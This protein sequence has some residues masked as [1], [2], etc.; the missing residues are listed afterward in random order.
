VRRFR[1][2]WLIASEQFDYNVSG[3]VPWRL[4][5]TPTVTPNTTVAPDGTTSGDTIAGITTGSNVYQY[6]WYGGIPTPLPLGVLFCPS[7][8]LALPNLALNG[9]FGDGSSWTLGAGWAITGGA[10]CATNASATI[11]E[12]V[13]IIQNKVYRVTYTVSG[14]AGGWVRSVCGGTN[15]GANRTANGTYVDS[16]TCSNASDPYLYFQCSGFTGNISN[17]SVYDISG[18][19]KLANPNGG[20]TYGSWTIDFSK[21]LVGWNRIVPGH[22]AVTPTTPFTAQGNKSDGFG[23]FYFSGT[24]PLSFVA[25]GAQINLG[26]KP[27]PYVKTVAAPVVR[28]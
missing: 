6:G 16:I 15:T 3:L 25:W 20:T 10:A 18:T 12:T 8:Y 11:K 5:G 13:G 19:I 21:L 22:P 4:I 26:S 9:T 17:V 24:G 2:N 23:F 28:S 1:E 7:V 27:F 14:Y